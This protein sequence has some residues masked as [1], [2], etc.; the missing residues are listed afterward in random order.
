VQTFLVVFNKDTNYSGSR[1][2]YIMK[3]VCKGKNQCY[4][5]F[6]VFFKKHPAAHELEIPLKLKED[7]ATKADT[8][9]EL[10]HK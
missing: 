9:N 4:F 10:K 3:A 6:Q 8:G 2:G 1:E 7:V 5:R